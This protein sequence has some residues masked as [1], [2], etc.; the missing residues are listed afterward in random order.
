MKEKL[1]MWS[2]AQYLAERT[3]ESRNK[4][5]DLLRALS[6]FSV[7]LG[8]WLLTAP[9]FETGT[10]QLFHLLSIVT[11][12]QWLT[13]IFQVMP[14]FFFVGGFSNLTSWE[15]SLRK[16]RAYSHW[17]ASRLQR[18][19]V[20]VL[21]LLAFWAVLALIGTLV[22]VPDRFIQIG[23]QIAFVP[24]WFLAVYIIVIILVPWTYKAWQQYRLKSVMFLIAGAVIVDLLFFLADLQLLGWFN[25][26]FIWLAVHQLG[27]A[28]QQG[29]FKST[30]KTF[31][32]FP[33]GLLT[34]WAM[35]TLGP[36]PLSLVGVP[37]DELS[38]TLPPKLPLLAL[39]FAQIGLLLSLQRI[40]RRWLSNR[41]PWTATVL[42]N[43]MIMTVFL[44]HSTA[45]MLVIGA[46]FWLW[47][48][49]F[50]VEPGTVKWWLARPV[51]VVLFFTATLPFL[52]LFSRFERIS[53]PVIADNIGR[54]RLFLGALLAC[55]GLGYLAL[56]GIGSSPHWL[57]DVMF[58]LL[59]LAG[60]AS[61][62]FGFFGSSRNSEKT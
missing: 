62:G 34:L 61:A 49:V 14:I 60:A 1:N 47:P 18:L 20:P 51:W 52:L 35:V 56:K 38:N 54:I 44:W 30:W 41:G 36:Y 50:A 33:A 10:P 46:G 42:V 55:C 7:V 3:P 28:W 40:A 4:Y 37:T 32:L 24:T 29:Y 39:G 57:I 8:H 58:L 21:P 59:P 17:L 48:D 15:S 19:L 27:Y 6:I 23:S 11:W 31:L 43:G 12:S 53:A 13:W 45:M 22:G 26:L 9:Y 5:V 2:H 16:N 25:Y